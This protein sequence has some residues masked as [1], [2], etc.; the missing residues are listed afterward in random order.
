M[1]VPLQ[2]RYAPAI[3]TGT[4]AA[5]GTT[6]STTTPVYPIIAKRFHRDY[7]IAG[8]RHYPTGILEG[9]LLLSSCRTQPI[10]RRP[11]LHTTHTQNHNPTPH[12]KSSRNTAT[13]ACLCSSLRQRKKPIPGFVFFCHPGSCTV[14]LCSLSPSLSP[15]ILDRS[16][17]LKTP[18][19]SP[20]R[21]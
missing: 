18:T 13:Y 2:L 14:C 6:P 15:P 21:K 1:P 9:P 8:N 10:V 12:A 5:S 19:S 11:P 17:P 16:T 7:C 20:G 3:H 4:I